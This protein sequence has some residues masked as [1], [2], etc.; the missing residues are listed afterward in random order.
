MSL[1]E[2]HAAIVAAQ[3]K[4]DQTRA[5]LQ[6]AQEAHMASTR[7][8]SEAQRAFD[9]E[10]KGLRVGAPRDS[11]WGALGARKAKA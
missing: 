3:A 1:D 7:A 9:D 2:A 8:L 11:D 10:V 6:Q 5:A 4:Y